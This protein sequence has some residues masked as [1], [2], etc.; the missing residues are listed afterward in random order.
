MFDK[1]KRMKDP[2]QG[3]AL[4]VAVNDWSFGTNPNVCKMKLVLE[5]PGVPTTTVKHDNVIWAHD[6]G[7]WPSQGSRLP[8]TVDRSEPTK[9]R[10]EWDEVKSVEQK[11][12]EY[13]KSEEQRLLD[14]AYGRKPPGTPDMPPGFEDVDPAAFEEDPE[15]RELVQMENEEV[16]ANLGPGAQARA[17]ASAASGTSGDAPTDV[18]ERLR[19]LDELKAIGELSEQEYQEQRQRII[20]SI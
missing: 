1:L 3:T 13:E 6:I 7:K 16:A 12:S 11:A 15:L 17:A 19:K 2:V 5:A 8:V 9:F 10:I 20:Q 4:V 18:A 14:Q